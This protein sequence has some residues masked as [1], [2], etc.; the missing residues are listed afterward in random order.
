MNE[1]LPGDWE[2]V[3]ENTGF[4]YHWQRNPNGD[5]PYP[6]IRVGDGDVEPLSAFNQ[7]HWTVEIYPDPAADSDGGAL[8][9]TH[10]SL[11]DA[12]SRVM[13]LMEEYPHD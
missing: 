2:N 4:A 13:E 8:R 11:D 1:P 7:N 3:S 10:E 9:S 5:P 6:S 12:L